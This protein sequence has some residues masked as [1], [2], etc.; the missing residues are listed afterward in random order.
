MSR[1]QDSWQAPN[2]RLLDQ[3]EKFEVHQWFK[4]NTKIKIFFEA[5]NPSFSKDEYYS[6]KD[7]NDIL[8]MFLK[9][10]DLFVKETGKVILTEPL[11]NAS[12]VYLLFY[13]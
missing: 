6:L 8:I 9:A 12:K 2:R 5:M 11:W 3:D 10:K 1:L 13:Y 7:C 4:P